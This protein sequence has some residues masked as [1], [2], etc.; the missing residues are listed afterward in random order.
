M[1][2]F[3][4]FSRQS[5]KNDVLS[6]L[7]VALALIPE[8][9][10]FAFVAGVD[11]MVGLYAAFIV[12]LVTAVLGGRPG[13]ISGATGAMAVVMVSLVAEHGIQ[14][15]F[16]AIMLAGVLQ[17]LAGIF[18]LGKFIRMVPHPVMIGFVNGLAIVI[19]LA[20][21]GQF[22][23]PD[24][25]G[26][27]QWMQGQQLYLMLGLVALTMFIIHFLPKLT[28]AVPSSLVAIITVTALVHGL[29]LESRT[30]I[31]FVR[32]M[33]G[34]ANAT[35]AGS[36]PT[37][38]VPEVGFNMETLQI[39]LPYSLVLAAV[40]LI[41]SLLTLTVIDEMTGTRGQGNRECVGQGLAN[42]TCSVFGAMGG[43]AM[44]GQSMINI[45]SGGRGR[46]SGITGAV[47][48]LLFI[49]FGS[50]LI[51]MIPLAALVGVMFMVVIGTFEWA[52]FKM[53]RKVPKHD[54]FAI[55]L[56][57]G[58]TVAADL[59]LAVIVG[60]IYSALVFAWDHAKHIYASSYVNAEGSKVYEVNGPLFFGSASHFLE[61]FDAKND[62]KD[63]IIDFAK[64]RVSDHS[65]IEA[66][67]TI[68]ERYA[69]QGKTLHIRHLSTECRSLLKKAGNLVEVNMLEDP[70]YKVATDTLG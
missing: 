27:M 63:V 22:K 62:P 64:S 3:P 16:A 29:D 70:T 53:A 46:L 20:Q 44:I 5:V 23:V 10:A 49:L 19:F 34:D 37:F 68:A 54:F 8:A 30:V 14:Y 58:V 12:G 35:L 24:A 39:I 38:A 6:G 45:N 32:S 33:S 21:L 51:E 67:D 50:A 61:L 13:M 48:L 9:V 17:I 60:V 2:E 42:V 66:I 41:E 52:S 65:A 15:L 31:D 18:K 4:Q 40:G 69:S 47:G 11:P 55:I 1:F 57:T 26:V 56:V 43:C 36:L 28:T 7:T 25:A 59:A